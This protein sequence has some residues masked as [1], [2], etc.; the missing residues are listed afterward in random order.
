MVVLE[1]SMGT[2]EMELYPDKA[3]L[4][5]QNFL[6]Y[7]DNHFYDGLI[8]HRVIDGFMIQTGGF[9]PDMTQKAGKPPI[10]NEAG[11]GLTNDKYTVA[12]ARTN[13]VHSATSQFF[14]N[15]TDN[16]FLNHTDNT[17]RGF[18][19]CVFGK[20]IEGKEVVDKIGKVKTGNKAGMNDVPLETVSILKA[21]R[22]EAAKDDKE[23]S[24]KK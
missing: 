2:M 23:K 10:D 24:E 16:A 17:Q 18:G 15:T 4:S 20:V 14:I 6:W 7:V 3:P 21:Y 19:Y 9:T 5:V 13:A 22:K 1:T 8:F 11:N 12:M